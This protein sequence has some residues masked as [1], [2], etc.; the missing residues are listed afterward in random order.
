MELL[1]S[2]RAQFKLAI[3][4]LTDRNGEGLCRSEGPVRRRMCDCAMLG[5]LHRTLHGKTWYDSGVQGWEKPVKVS[6][7]HLLVEMQ[8]VRKETGE[9][10]KMAQ[11]KPGAHFHEKCGPWAN[12]LFD[13]VRWVKCQRRRRRLMKNT[14]RSSGRNL[15]RPMMALF[16]LLP[17]NQASQHRNSSVA[18]CSS[19]S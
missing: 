13:A 4:K 19:F 3:G 2:A 15:G 16:P 1:G 10:S 8:G 5:A 14:L 6:M 12:T 18:C 17:A 11:L 9:E 7:R